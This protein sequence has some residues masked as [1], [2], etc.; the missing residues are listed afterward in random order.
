MTQARA[1]TRNDRRAAELRR[2]IEEAPPG[3]AEEILLEFVRE[4]VVK[5]L[6]LDPSHP[7]DRRHRLMD[8]GFDSLMAVELRNRLATGLGLSR[9]LPATLVFD[10]P[11]IEAIADYLAEEVLERTPAPPPESRPEE[12]AVSAAE[13]ARLSEA[14]A[15]ALLLQ[16]L[17]GLER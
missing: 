6:R 10:H 9:R 17:E 12:T 8:L 1:A 7:A 3:Q 13:L 4:S 11:T 5:V 15:E 16:K 14:E 2:Q